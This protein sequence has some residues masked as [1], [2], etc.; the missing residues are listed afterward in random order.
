VDLAR[1]YWF[2]FSILSEHRAITLFLFAHQDDEMGAFGE[3]D[4]VISQGGRPI[5]LYLTDGG[6]GRAL[7]ALRN[8]ESTD[9][10]RQLG[11]PEADLHFIGTQIAIP[12]GSLV[13]HL[14]RAFAAAIDVCSAFGAI[15]KVVMHAWEG[16]HQ[17]HDAAHLVGLA[18]A[19]HFGIEQDSRQFTLYRYN[20][21]SILPFVI[22]QPL[23]SNGPVLAT[24]ISRTRRRH[25]VKLL[26]L[27][28][29]QKKSMLGLF[30]FIVWHYLTAGTQLLQPVDLSRIAEDPHA[31]QLLYE[32]RSSMTR[33]Q[34]RGQS[35]GFCKARGL[36]AGETPATPI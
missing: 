11:V 29:S 16:G 21:K 14:D 12:D 26:T 28:R 31:G 35:A 19:K 10:M 34:F 30:P 23:K 7:P 3:I 8:T 18:M 24:K 5:C 9:V 13:R 32:K 1:N 22:F 36:P 33:E 27:Y 20:A 6:A 15:N 2:G 4:S 25:Y 17:D